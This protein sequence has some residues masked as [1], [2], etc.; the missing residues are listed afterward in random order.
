MGRGRGGFV[1][2][3]LAMGAGA[4]FLAKR[5]TYTSEAIYERSDLRANFLNLE[6]LRVNLIVI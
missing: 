4:R 1:V 6:P 2:Q 5:V 3:D